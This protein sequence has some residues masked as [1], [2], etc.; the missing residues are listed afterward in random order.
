MAGRQERLGICNHMATEEELYNI[1][2]DVCSCLVETLTV[3]EN[4]DHVRH[5]DQVAKTQMSARKVRAMHKCDVFEWRG[6]GKSSEKR[7]C[8]QYDWH[9]LFC[10][11]LI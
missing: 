9:L 1:S 6:Q 7:Y 5:M 8:A 11:I 10:H 3:R 2:L 4:F